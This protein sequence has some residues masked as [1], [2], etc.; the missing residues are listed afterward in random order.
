MKKY[1]YNISLKELPQEFEIIYQNLYQNYIYNLEKM[2]NK[3]KWKKIVQYI[4]FPIFCVF[5]GVVQCGGLG[6]SVGSEFI[7]CSTAIAS[8]IVLVISSVRLDQDK[9]EYRKI[10]KNKVIPEFVKLINNQLKFKSFDNELFK[11]REDYRTAGFDKKMFTSFDSNDYV[12]G[13]V[14]DEIFIKL[15]DVHV[16]FRENKNKCTEELF[17]GIFAHTKCGK[18][19]QTEIKITKNKIKILEQEHRVEMDS[20]EF[21][22]YFDIYSENKIEAM[23]LLTSDVMETLTNFYNK[24]SL[25]FEIIFRNNTIYMRFFTGPMFEPQIFRNSMDK[26]TLAVYFCILKFIVDVSKNV[27]KALQEVEI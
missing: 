14:D 26:K 1:K 15:C 27:N 24:Y 11:M 20:V 6:D 19:I 4:F 13:F 7:I 21:E 25:D 10:Y 17:K 9:R 23:Q 8:F 22:K 3:I 5:M 18:D 12:E 2:R 16:Q